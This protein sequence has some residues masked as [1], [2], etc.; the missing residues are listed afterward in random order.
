MTVD[1]SQVTQ[2]IEEMLSQGSEQAADNLLEE[3]RAAAPVGGAD[4]EHQGETRDSGEVQNRGGGQGSYSY[5]ISFPTPQ[6]LFTDQ[7][8]KPHEITP[9]SKKA[10]AFKVG[11]ATVIVKRV[12]HPGTSA[13]E[14]F[15]KLATEEK[16]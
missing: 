1:M 3:M 6:A 12:D 2:A 8:T 4:D 16:W 7:G 14:W 10:L 15:S 5:E 11:G 13:T 9:T